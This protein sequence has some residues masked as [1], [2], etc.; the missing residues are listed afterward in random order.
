MMEYIK[1]LIYIICIVAVI[2]ELIIYFIPNKSI[3]LPLKFI[4]SLVTIISVISIYKSV[5]EIDLNF[6]KQSETT[7]NVNENLLN[8]TQLEKIENNVKNDLVELLNNEAVSY[9]DININLFVEEYEI[10][11][12]ECEVYSKDKKIKNLSNDLSVK[13]GLTVKTYYIGE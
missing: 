8:D 7:V 6:F 10:I 11:N 5:N 13:L 12:I 1:E 4:I 3:I 9:T 2:G